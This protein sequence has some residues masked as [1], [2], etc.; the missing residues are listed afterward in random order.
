VNYSDA[1]QGFY[2]PS[3]MVH[4]DA[5]R[6][7]EAVAPDLN[8][9][10]DLKKYWHL[11][12]D[13]EQPQK[14][15]FH[16]CILGWTCETVNTKKLEAY[17]LLDYFVNFRPGAGAA[18][19]AAIASAYNRGAPWLGY[20]WGPTWILGKYDLTKL[21]EPPYNE[22]AWQVLA[23]G[24][25]P[26]LAVAYP[27]I[28]VYI[29]VNSAFESDYPVVI[30]FLRRYKTSNKLVSDALAF[31]QEDNGRTAKDA[32]LYFLETREEVWGKWVP[33]IVKEAVLESLATPKDEHSQW[34][35]NLHEP[36]NFF[37]AWMVNHHQG[38]FEA[39]AVP[40]RH[41]ILGLERVLKRLPW[42]VIVVIFA[43]AAFAAS[44]SLFTTLVV[45]GCLLLV[46]FLGLWKLAIQTLALMLISTS[47]AIA[48]GIPIGIFLAYNARS[49]SVILSILDAMQ[50]MPSFVYLIPALMLF[51]LGK[52]PALFATVIYSIGPLIRLTDHGIR[53]VDPEVIEAAKSF[54]AT[55][56]QLLGG[57]QLPLALPTI[58]AG[59]NQTTMLAL[60]MVVIASMIGARGLGEEVLLGIQKLD[61]GRGFTAGIG[62]VAL[63]IVLDRITQAF[64]R[65]LDKTR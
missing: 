19:D 5:S 24:N 3:Y 12:R 50:T 22:A 47:L 8:H 2:V 55:N 46:V 37:V 33:P 35:F 11:F 25:N 40:V 49:R 45:V 6:G 51:G 65:R 56:R 28:S 54:G 63:A 58:M 39:I 48:L 10:E 30:E 38:T 21:E 17:G 62:I 42:W 60:S 57:V 59:I 29:G 18:L 64:G 13:P 4:G 15:R 61:V 7:I 32:A 23:S 16:N 44:R 1:V 41:V 14:G 27:D 31:M 9:V 26:R 34:H 53:Q 20:Y 43:I 52:V 36:I